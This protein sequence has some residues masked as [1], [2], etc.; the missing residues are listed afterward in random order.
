M[1]CENIS[2][3][4]NIRVDLLQQRLHTIEFHLIPQALHE[5]ERHFLVVQ[6]SGQSPR[7]EL[8]RWVS[9]CQA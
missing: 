4:R 6:V 8:P 7:R 3:F 5:L 1:L 9:L 2:R